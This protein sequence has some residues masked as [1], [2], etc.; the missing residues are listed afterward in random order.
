MPYPAPTLTP[1]H[2]LPRGGGAAKPAGGMLPTLLAQ[3]DYIPRLKYT[4][5]SNRCKCGDHDA[6][7]RRLLAL[8]LESGL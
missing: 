5:V 4:D 3:L 1:G 6:A 8:L 7:F 2:E